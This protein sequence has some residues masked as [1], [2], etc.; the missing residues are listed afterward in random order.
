ML[1]FWRGFTIKISGCLI[2]KNEEK[3]ITRCIES[4]L[5][6]IDELIVVDTGSTDNTVAIAEKFNAKIYHF[7]WIDDFSAARN[8][9]ISKA[10]GDWIIF[11]DADEFLSE[12]NLDKRYC[13]RLKT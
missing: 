7:T 9:A 11:L 5:P 13:N 12:A 4:M 8:Y 10:T 1:F 3:N 2:V 6:V